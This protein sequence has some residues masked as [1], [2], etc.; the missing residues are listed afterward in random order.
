MNRLLVGV[1]GQRNQLT[2]N[3]VHLISQELNLIHINMRQP[4]LNVLA[5]V[6]GSTPQSAAI[7]AGTTKID[8]LKCTVAAFERSFLAAIYELNSDY[9]TDIANLTLA[10][11]TAGFT[12]TIKDLFSGHVVSGISRPKEADF[13]RERGGILVHVHHGE[14]WSDFHPLSVK[15]TDVF[16][17][18]KNIIAHDKRSVA[19]LMSQIKN[20][21]L[22]KAA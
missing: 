13:I 22:Q 4:F 17:D 7:L 1:T 2:K 21:N 10:R 15:S 19:A 16:I 8:E 9:F 11:S 3:V 6:T 14:G 18:A 5:A 20:A 12:E